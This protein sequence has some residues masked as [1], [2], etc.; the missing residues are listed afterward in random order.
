MKTCPNCGFESDK[1]NTE[2]P[3]CGIIFKKWEEFH[4]KKTKKDGE[5]RFKKNK[6]EKEIKKANNKPKK[7]AFTH[8]IAKRGR[9][10]RNQEFETDDIHKSKT[11]FLHR[12]LSMR[13][14]IIFGGIFFLVVA[15][16]IYYQYL[17]V[18]KKKFQESYKILKTIQSETS[19]GINYGRF[20][21]LIKNL[22]TEI[23]ILKD[24]KLTNNEREILSDYIDVFNTYRSRFKFALRLISK[25]GRGYLSWQ[26]EKLFPESL[27]GVFLSNM[28]PWVSKA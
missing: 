22:K 11:L 8:Q 7:S 14:F 23:L 4:S 3:K 28:H 26:G 24:M 20:E 5:E 2:C 1:Q 19:L 27:P 9:K 6:T 10:D 21:Q 25:S 18:D 17:R 16:F 13:F 12:F 15:I